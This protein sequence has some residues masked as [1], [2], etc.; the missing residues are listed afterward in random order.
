MHYYMIIP[1]AIKTRPLTARQSFLIE[2]QT[3]VDNEKLMIFLTERLRR[4]FI[5][6]DPISA[7][8]GYLDN[9]DMLDKHSSPVI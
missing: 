6:T 9:R 5:I 3:C 7:L 1:N 2:G 4:L 8:A